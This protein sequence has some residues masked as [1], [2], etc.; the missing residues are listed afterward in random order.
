MMTTRTCCGRQFNAPQYSS[1]SLEANSHRNNMGAVQSGPTEHEFQDIA[2]RTGFS[3]EQIRNL[4]KR[5][6][7][8][9]NHQE[10]LRRE[11]F[12]KVLNLSLN[13]IRAKIIQAFFDKRN[14]GMNE[15]G[16]VEEIGF[17][18]FL[19]VMSYFKPPNK[20]LTEDETEA[21][22]T[23]KL[24]FLFNMHDTDNDGTITLE[25][26]R[27]LVEKL[28]STCETLE[29]DTAQ[30]IADAAML[31]VARTTVVHMEPHEVYEGVTFEQF[32][33]ILKGIELETKMNVRFL[34]VN[35]T[36]MHCGK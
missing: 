1:W 6:K 26:Y 10:T 36:T 8:L 25:E 28:L 31:E 2:D 7:W 33:Q 9:N 17:E 35:T 11:D 20:K 34:Q 22:R 12:E 15:V 27:H 5:F 19:T 32:Q 30:D 18:E 23:K 13:P 16:L 3:L 29:Q 14:F 4:H 24:R 21:L